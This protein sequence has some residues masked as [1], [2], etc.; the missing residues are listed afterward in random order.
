[1]SDKIVPPM[2]V[3]NTGPLDPKPPRKTVR[4][5][6]TLLTILVCVGFLFMSIMG[7]YLL[8][9]VKKLGDLEVKAQ[10]AIS[11]FSIV[12]SL[13]RHSKLI[14][15]TAL[16]T[17]DQTLE[18]ENILSLGN[19]AFE[20]GSSNLRM[21]SMGNRVQYY[22][23]MQ[24]ISDSD[25]NWISD[26]RTITVK[27]PHPIVDTEM[28]DIQQDP[29]QIIFLGNESW[30]DW[31]RNTGKNELAQKAK[32]NLRQYVLRAAKTRYY[33]STAEENALREVERLLHTLIYPIDPQIKIIV[34]F[35]TDK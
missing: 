15:Q 9:M 30:I 3:E 23:P 25:I 4:F 20:L 7:W 34:E 29:R 2:N 5:F 35:K 13:Q 10:T 11:V 32:D 31:A 16:I 27:I 21:I 19:Y 22:I 6:L 14:V 24:G 28:V 8:G 26:T 17:V 18:K 1:M 33:I 12:E